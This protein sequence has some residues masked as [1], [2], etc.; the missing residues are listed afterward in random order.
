ML[1][2]ITDGDSVVAPHA[3]ALVE[4]LHPSYVPQFD[5]VAP[6][7]GALVETLMA[8][9]FGRDAEVAPHA[10]ALVETDFP[11]TSVILV[12]SRLTQAR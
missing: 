9:I 2:R 11:A 4:T 1:N 8:A 6:H 7:A 10:G 3:G 12:R 5:L